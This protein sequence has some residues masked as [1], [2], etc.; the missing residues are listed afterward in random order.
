MSKNNVKAIRV[1]LAKLIAQD[2]IKS[3][4]INQIAKVLASTPYEIKRLDICTHGFCID[5]I[6]KNVKTALGE[7]AAAR[8]IDIRRVESFP[9]G[10]IDPNTRN[11]RVTYEIENLRNEVSGG[12]F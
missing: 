9:W 1:H 11:L 8:G 6:T 5:I 7:L 2:K 12:G 3:S 4:K 10:I